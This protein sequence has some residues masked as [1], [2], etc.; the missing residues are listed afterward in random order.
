[1]RMIFVGLMAAALPF[2]ARAQTPPPVGCPAAVH[3]QFDFW[4]GKWIVRDSAGKQVG[5]SD[6][7]VEASGCALVEHWKDNGG[8]KGASINYYDPGTQHWNQLWVGGRGGILH[9]S[10]ALQG[11]A[12]V[13]TGERE[14]A[15]GHVNDRITWTPL[16]D[17]RVR[18]EW[19]I[20][21]DGGSTWQTAFDGYYQRAG[22]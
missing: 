4:A 20:S 9:L 14:T 5:T 15:K 17:G 6:V 19:V 21:T 1:M 8:V 22:G 12:M 13:L 18:Q 7:T 11:N 2:P 10:G 3:H 16:A